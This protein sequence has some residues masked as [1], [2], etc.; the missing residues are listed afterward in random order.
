MLET[1]QVSINM[2]LDKQFVVH[3]NNGILVS[4]RKERTAD[5][6]HNMYEFHRYN[7]LSDSRALTV[8]FRT[9]VTWYLGKVRVERV[10]VVRRKR[11]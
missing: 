4:N 1:H 7:M 11:K 2:R 8:W 9:V 5:K 3:S 10:G 6:C